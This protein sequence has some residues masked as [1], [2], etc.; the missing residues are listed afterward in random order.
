MKAK[1]HL[2]I[3]WEAEKKLDKIQHPFTI[4]DWQTKNKRNS[5]NMI[6]T[7]YDKFTA[8]I[9]LNGEK[10]KTFPLR[11]GTRQGCPFLP[12]LFNIVT[13][14]LPRQLGEK[15]NFKSIQVGKEEVKLSGWHYLICRKY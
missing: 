1:N 5:F 11:S 8:N 15:R 7:I 3:K 9:I 14:I 10:Q 6:K 12:H 13:K 2:V 4:K